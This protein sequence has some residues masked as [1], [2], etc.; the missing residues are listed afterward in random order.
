MSDS[1][2][3]DAISAEQEARD[4]LERIGVE[5]AQFTSG[6]LVELANLI[7]ANSQRGRYDRILARGFGVSRSPALATTPEQ[8]REVERLRKATD[9]AVGWLM[10]ML[11]RR[12]YEENAELRDL[13]DHLRA[14]RAPE[15]GIHG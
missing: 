7:A 5:N 1:G 11:E 14:S 15:E 12:E 10:A 2:K 13:M 9:Y 8:E 4:M 3:P 6:D